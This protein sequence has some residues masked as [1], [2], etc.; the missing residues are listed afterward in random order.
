MKSCE[1]VSVDD[2]LAFRRIEGLFAKSFSIRSDSI[3]LGRGDFGID[4]GLDMEMIL[5]R[6]EHELYIPF[7][8]AI[9][10][11]GL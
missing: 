4:L 3:T 11:L 9:R 5:E 6:V 7:L 10:N 8:S 1:W 2:I